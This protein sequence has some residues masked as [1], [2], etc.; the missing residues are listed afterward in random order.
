MVI[1]RKIDDV[2]RLAIPKEVRRQLRWM[3]GDEIELVVNNDQSI[4]L[5][6][7]SEDALADLYELRK[8]WLIDPDISQKFTELIDTIVDKQTTE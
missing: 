7:H 5:R 8:K 3:G 2:G 4:T 1:V 6:K